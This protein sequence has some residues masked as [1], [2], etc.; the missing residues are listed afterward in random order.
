MINRSFGQI[1]Y[2]HIAMT[3][4]TSSIKNLKPKLEM[5]SYEKG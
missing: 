1:H 4:Y 5:L 3:S 2:M